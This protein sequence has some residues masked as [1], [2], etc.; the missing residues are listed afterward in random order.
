M[1]AEGTLVLTDEGWLR[2]AVDSEIGKY[3]RHL[4]YLSVNRTGRLHSPMRGS[5][6]TVADPDSPH[7]GAA[8]ARLGST[9]PFTITLDP[10]TNGNAIWLPVICQELQ[11]FQGAKPLHYCAG[12]LTQEKTK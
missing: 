2:L 4:Y 5:H 11:P 10:R 1:T 12:Y 9:F 8:L 3:L 6:V 7:W